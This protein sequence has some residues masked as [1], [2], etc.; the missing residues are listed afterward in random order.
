MI[1]PP[2]SKA[3]WAVVP[4]KRFDRAK[5]R[6]ASVLAPGARRDLAVAMLADVLDALRGTTALKG[7]VVVTAD[8]EAAVMARARGFETIGNPEEAG[9]NAAVSTGLAYVQSRRG[10][11]LVTPA[12]IPLVTTV[13][14]GEAIDALDTTSLVIEPAARDGGANLL[15][16]APADLFASS[17]GRDSAAHPAANARARGVEP[18]FLTLAGATR[19]VDTPEDLAELR[20][21]DAKWT[22]VP[23]GASARSPPAKWKGLRNDDF[24]PGRV[25]AGQQALP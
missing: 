21:I 24:L 15:A 12:E 5:S 2:A 4:V 20:R 7:V 8:A 16:L 1:T 22:R 18:A 17:F 3:V 23:L 14:L 6:L 11:A 9:V 19:D 25:P 13:E 10:A